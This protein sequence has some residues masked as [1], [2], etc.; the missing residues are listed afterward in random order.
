MSKVIQCESE[1]TY[2][3]AFHRTCSFQTTFIPLKNK[4][5]N[6]FSHPVCLMEIGLFPYRVTFWFLTWLRMIK[7]PPN[8]SSQRSMFLVPVSFSPPGYLSIHPVTVLAM[9]NLWCG[10]EGCSTVG[11]VTFHL[12][13][14]LC[15]LLYLI[16]YVL[17]PFRYR[18]HNAWPAVLWLVVRR[19][20][21]TAQKHGTPVDSNIV[22]NS[23]FP[24]TNLREWSPSCFKKLVMMCLSFQYSM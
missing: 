10:G 22:K 21:I 23:W 16:T 5:L 7:I 18:I 9:F 8:I 1:T 14:W 20:W 15:F 12:D 4:Y 6:V 2:F 11:F 19:W 13:L 24:Q 17:P 3:C